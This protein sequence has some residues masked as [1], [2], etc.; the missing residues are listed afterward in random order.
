MRLAAIAFLAAVVPIVSTAR[1]EISDNSFF[2]EEAYNQE[3][4]VVQHIQTFLW[5]WAESGSADGFTYALTQEWPL[6]GQ[7]HQISYTVPYERAWG[8]GS[9]ARG[10]GDVQIHYRWQALAETRSRVAFA[11]RLSLLLP[12]GDDAD[13]LGAGTAGVQVNLPVSKRLAGVHVHVNAGATL[14]PNARV[15]LGP[16]LESPRHDLRAANLG[17]SVIGLLSERFHALLETVTGV[18]EEIGASGERTQETRVLVAPGARYAIDRKDGGQWVL[19]VAGP[20]GVNEAQDD[21]GLLLYLSFEHP[22]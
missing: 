6:S 9:T 1:A 11:P 8:G 17:F 3:A 22:F 2:I 13:G 14:V 20:I 10:L 16:G 12:T 18:Q 4:G 19:G 15:S 7:A 21:I 5:T